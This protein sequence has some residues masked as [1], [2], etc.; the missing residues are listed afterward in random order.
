MYLRMRQQHTYTQSCDV[1]LAEPT[2][3]AWTHREKNERRPL[4]HSNYF[5][6]SCESNI[7]DWK[8]GDTAFHRQSTALKMK[9]RVVPSFST[10]F[11]DDTSSSSVP[12]SNLPFPLDIKSAGHWKPIAQYSNQRRDMERYSAIF[13]GLLRFDQAVERLLEDSRQYCLNQILDM[14]L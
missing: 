5:P 1:P 14:F 10:Y 13:L 2:I 11:K 9:K 3:E 4:Q 6:P 12:R 8:D 7:R